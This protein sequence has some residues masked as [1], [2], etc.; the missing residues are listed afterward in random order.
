MDYVD[1]FYSQ[2]VGTYP[3]NEIKIRITED[4]IDYL[5]DNKLT[6][7]KIIETLKLSNCQDCL[8]PENLPDEL[9][10]DSL[11]KRNRFYYHNRLQLISKAPTL[12][13]LTGKIITYPF[14]KEII[15]N[16]TIKDLIDYFYTTMDISKELMDIKKDSGSFNYLF[17]KYSAIKDIET[18][19]LIL[20]MIDI[21]KQ[22][23]R[24][25]NIINIEE[26]NSEAI[27]TL[28]SW[29]KAARIADA[30]KIIWR[31]SRWLED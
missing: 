25:T 29:Q 30:N 13:I 26:Y 1:F 2:C 24:V 21:T 10:N 3:N 22:N 9:W 15:I 17:K 7:D 12:N 16:F 14:Y 31:S 18:L 11:I 6:S 8:Y 19:D 5:K 4:T 20:V 28:R 27:E 23:H